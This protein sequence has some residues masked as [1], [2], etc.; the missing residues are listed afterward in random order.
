MTNIDTRANLCDGRFMPKAS[1]RIICLTPP[2]RGAIATILIEGAGA[3]ELVGRF[4]FPASK[5][6]L[7]EYRAG[8]PAFGRFSSQSGSSEEMIGRRRSDEAVE[9]HCH[10]GHAVVSM[11]QDTLVKQGGRLMSW[12]DWAADHHSDPIAAAARVALASARTERT[13]AILLDQFNGAFRQTVDESLDSL[14]DNDLPSGRRLLQTLLARYELGRHLTNCW[15]VVFA[16]LPNVGKSSLVNRLVGYGRSIVDPAPG[17]TRDVLTATTAIDGWPVELADTAGL[18]VGGPSVE[19]AGME[20][21]RQRLVAADLVVLTFDSSRAFSDADRRLFDAH[22]GALLVHNKS[23]LPTCSTRGRPGGL[24]T[25]ALRGQ[26]I[27][28]LLHAISERLVPDPPLPGEAVPFAAAQRAY[29]QAT[30]DAVQDG[31]AR[32]AIELLSPMTGCQQR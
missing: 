20:L 4:F 14:R 26:G 21:T 12:Q 7:A 22:P 31:K 2:G 3:V 11:V 25:S 32:S 6:A 13:A 15:R 16:G 19:R 24:R 18:R 28:R 23:D 9:L 10:G 29:L 5:R 17:T 30:L 27:D 1:P 8:Q